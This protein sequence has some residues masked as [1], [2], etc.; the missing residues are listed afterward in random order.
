MCSQGT[1]SGNYPRQA[2]ADPKAEQNQ[3]ET[4]MPIE[5][6]SSEARNTRVQTMAGV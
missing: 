5:V 1:K 3:F 6:S 2:I 4:G